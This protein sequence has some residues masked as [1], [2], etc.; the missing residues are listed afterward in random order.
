MSQ[1]NMLRLLFAGGGGFSNL[2][3][4][5]TVTMFGG[6][7]DTNLVLGI[8]QTTFIIIIHYK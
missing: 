3:S 4:S 6:G 8:E 7:A 1:R 2:K 5:Q